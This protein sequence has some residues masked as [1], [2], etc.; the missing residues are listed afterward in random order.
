MSMA[1]NVR[2]KY[3]KAGFDAVRN[4]AGAQEVCLSY[5]K[6]IAARA[7]AQTKGSFVADVRPGK[8]RCHAMV[9]PA[10]GGAGDVAA[11]DNL[12]KNILARARG[13]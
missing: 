9:K 7:N 2:F 6:A 3:S 10:D 13:W 11:R 5:A 4:S 12:R 1:S 8:S